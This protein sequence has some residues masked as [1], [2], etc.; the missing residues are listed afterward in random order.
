MINIVP[1]FLFGFIDILMKLEEKSRNRFIPVSEKTDTTDNIFYDDSHEIS[2][3][4]ISGSLHA[5]R[6]IEK[7]EIFGDSF[8]DMPVYAVISDDENVLPYVLFNLEDD[9]GKTL[10]RIIIRNG[11]TITEDCKTDG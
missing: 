4:E 9:D 11:E 10:F 7:S 8:D 2:V 1:V 5:Y 3:P 6:I